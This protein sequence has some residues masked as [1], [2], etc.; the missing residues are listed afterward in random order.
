MKRGGGLAPSFPRPAKRGEGGERRSRE[1]GEGQLL[2]IECFQ[3]RQQHTV[4]ICQHIVI[5]ETEHAV[6]F[7]REISVS[8]DIL[9][10]LRMVSA[11]DLNN[12]SSIA[13]DEIRNE[14]PDRF[15]PDKLEPAQPPIAE[16]KPQFPLGIGLRASQFSLNAN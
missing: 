7:T 1:P 3:D 14:R 10:A 5:P 9:C 16:S 13:A 4:S 15:L 12:Q 2:S 6:I 11:I 8:D